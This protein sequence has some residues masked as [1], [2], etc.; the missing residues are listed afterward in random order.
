MP[1]SLEVK[2]A[3]S[4]NRWL[5][6]RYELFRPCPLSMALVAIST[7]GK[8]SQMLTVTD[9]I[10][11]VMDRIVIY[12]HSHRLDPAWQKLKERIHQK[13]ISQGEDPNLHP[14]CFENLTSLPKVLA[15]QRERVQDAKERG[16]SKL[17][18]LLIIL[19]DMLGEMQ[20]NKV[21]DSIV[22]RGRHAGISVLV[23]SQVVRGIGS[24]ARKNFR[25][26]VS[27]A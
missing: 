15:L 9:A 1:H 10:F 21:L 17:P 24:Q 8:T 12:S 18:Q 27:A 7:G 23:D 19:S 22:T 2:G 25:H 14:F 16:D 5:Q 11:P 6:P 13:M 4:E 3:V 20:H 26:G